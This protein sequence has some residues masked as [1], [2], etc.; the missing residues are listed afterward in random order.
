MSKRIAFI[1]L[2][3]MGFP[4][5]GH[6]QQAGHQVTVFNRTESKARAWQTQ[7]GGEIAL[8][9]AAAAQH[10][11]LVFTCVGND[12]DLRDVLLGAE[13]AL[14]NIQPNTVLIDHTTASADVARE[15]AQIALEKQC[16]FIDAPVSGGQQ[17]AENGQLTIMCGGDEQAFQQA[18]DVMFCFAKA[19]TLMGP[20]GSGQLTKMVNQI[21]VGGV[22]QGLAE[23]LSF[24]EHA[25]LDLQKVIDAISQGAAGS[26]QMTNRHATMISGEYE[27]GFAVDWMRKDLDICLREARQNGTDLTITQ[28]INNFYKDVQEM[29]GSRWDTS[30][31][32]K[33]LQG[34]KTLH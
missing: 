26:W 2:G 9:P 24:A 14:A 10:A 28:Q 1:G 17:G 23:G 16:A 31:L 33:R 32:Y 5:A 12:N 8:T 15:I 21:C 25:G 6:L 7:Y 18:Q 19:I 3:V 30:S 11:E 13:G 20:T 22:L 34:R 4:M 27:H 29:G